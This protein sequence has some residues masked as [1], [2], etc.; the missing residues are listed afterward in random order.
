VKAFY[1]WKRRLQLA[2]RADNH[3]ALPARR[4]F[5]PVTVRVVDRASEELASIEAD[6]PNGVRLRIPTANA[7]LACRLV[8]VVATARTGWGGSR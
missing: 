6:L 7:C 4:A 3:P 5:V 2:D 1:S 8:R